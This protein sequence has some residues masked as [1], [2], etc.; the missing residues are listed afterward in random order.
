MIVTFK[1]LQETDFPLLVTWLQTPHVARW[2]SDGKI[3]DAEKV[4][5]KYASY[6]LGYKRISYDDK[7]AEEHKPIY[8]FIIFVDSTPIGYIQY[9]NVHDFKRAELNDISDNVPASCAA[10]DL[11]IGNVDFIGKGLGTEIIKF[12][13][14][15]QAKQQFDY[16][17]VDPEKENQAAIRTY[18]KAGFT[19]LTIDA[20]NQETVFMLASCATK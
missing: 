17:L 9:Y 15:E 1:K 20:H 14:Q 8:P 10:L 16:C 19:P 11:F 13:L 3:W 12:F 18:E 5:E 2:W 6:V 7:Q 4:Q